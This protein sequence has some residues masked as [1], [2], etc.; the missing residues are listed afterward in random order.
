MSLTPS[1]VVRRMEWRRARII[2]WWQ[3][4]R[5]RTRLLKAFSDPIAQVFGQNVPEPFA[6]DVEELFGDFKEEICRAT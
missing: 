5:H 4:K 3:W 6:K 2:R 1:W